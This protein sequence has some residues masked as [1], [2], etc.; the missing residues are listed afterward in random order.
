VPVWYEVAA[1]LSSGQ[2]VQG[3][4]FRRTAGRLNPPGG[5]AGR[6][7]AATGEPNATPGAAPAR[8][9]AQVLDETAALA[10]IIILTGANPTL[11]TEYAVVLA[12]VALPP[13]Y[14]PVLLIAA[15]ATTWANA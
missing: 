11:V 8:D 7:A 13:T 4:T 2:V 15:I 10:V 6:A 14:L 1:E 9:Q 5:G 12:V 3:P